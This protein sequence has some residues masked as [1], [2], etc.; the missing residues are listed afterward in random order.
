MQIHRLDLNLLAVFECIYSQGSVTRA[1]EYLHLT[2]PSVSHALNRL[3]DAL[4]DPLFVRDGKRLAPTERAQTLIQPVRAALRQIEGAVS[5]LDNF[6]PQSAELE[7]VIGMRPIMESAFF[8]E[9]A[10]TFI[11]EAPQSR[12]LSSQF[13]RDNLA[14]E[15][16][17]GDIQLALDV[18]LQLPKSIRR[19]RVAQAPIIVIGRK[20]HP[21]LQEGQLT[22][23]QYLQHEHLLVSSR[24]KGEGLEDLLLAREGR[25]RTIVSRCQQ[26]TTALQLLDSTDLL[27]TVAKSLVQET[28]LQAYSYQTA[29]LN[30][31]EVETYLYWHESTDSSKAQ[32]WLRSLVERTFS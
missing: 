17:R 3:R 20:G 1:A 23:E 14:T 30:A 27:L 4:D 6:E 29:P 16:S 7:M 22:L 24:R 15:L 10:R 19:I 2:Q 11:R 26:M 13:D 5:N 32:L 31:P 8:P 25:Y 9:I 12:L 21:A 28:V 18:N